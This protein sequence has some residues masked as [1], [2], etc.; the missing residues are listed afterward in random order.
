MAQT[1]NLKLPLIDG[2]MT[3]DVP[4]DMNALAEAVDS[5]VTEALG[6]ITVP[7]ATT[8][9]KGIVQ[10]S[11]ATNSASETTAATSKAVKTAYDA[12]ADA[13]STAN[14]A[15]SA[16]SAAQSTANAANT[17]AVAASNAVGPLAS[18]LTGAK[19]NTVA[20]INELFTNVSDGKNT[21]A[22][23][24]TGKGVP[25]SGS[26]TFPVLAQKIGQI[27]QG[28]K[29][30]SGNVQRP[31][32]DPKLIIAGLSFTPSLVRVKATLLYNNNLDRQSLFVLTDMTI[33]NISDSTTY[34][35]VYVYGSS[36]KTSTAPLLKDSQNFQIT[37][38]I[39]TD[40]FQVIPNSYTTDTW[41]YSFDWEAYE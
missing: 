39:N 24:I 37:G 18:L 13:K 10:L 1:A 27:Y 7:D 15:N 12:A 2:T 31:G 23:A 9:Q 19:T 5:S 40:G 11:S 32:N 4:R 30:A 20:A 25:A 6:E 26:D 21:I 3:A 33:Q 35:G 38:R 34:G 29:Y 36:G 22:S 8:A 14:A 28:K 16:A 17:A 41:K